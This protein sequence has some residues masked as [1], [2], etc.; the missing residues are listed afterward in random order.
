M[1]WAGPGLPAP[2]TQSHPHRVAGSA[3]RAA[4]R[5]ILRAAVRS[6]GRARERHDGRALTA[7]PAGRAK[8]R[9]SQPHAPAIGLVLGVSTSVCQGFMMPSC[10]SQ[11]AS[12]RYA[13]CE[14]SAVLDLVYV[15][16]L[17][18][19]PPAFGRHSE[20]CPEMLPADR[21]ANY[22]LV[23]VL[24]HDLNGDLQ[25]GNAVVSYVRSILNPSG[26]WGGPR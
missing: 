3:G 19:Q 11:S 13:K 12:P 15:Y 24:Q 26:P 22:H 17:Y 20:Q 8:G 21:R 1:E 5:K 16:G 25:I 18:R 14:R 10:R 4:V 7:T 23:A 2:D 9:S 6:A